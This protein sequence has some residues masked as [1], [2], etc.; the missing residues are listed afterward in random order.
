VAA[1]GGGARRCAGITLVEVMLVV[2]VIGVIASR[3]APHFHVALEQARVDAAAAGLRSLWVAERMWWLEERSFS[4]SADALVARRLLDEGLI[5]QTAPFDFTLLDA[6]AGSFSAR[7]VR[8]GSDEWAGTLLID[9]TGEITGTI[10][11]TS[12]HHVSPQTH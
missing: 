11:D 8:S 9:E 10:Q 2:A 6:D 3:A 4:D 7:M 5:A 12:G 1:R